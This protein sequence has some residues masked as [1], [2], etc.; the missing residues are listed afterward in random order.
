MKGVN[1]SPFAP[2]MNAFVERVNG[3]IRREA[4]EHYLLFSENQVRKIVK[5][6]VEYYN[7]HR[8]HQGV[9]RTPA[10]DQVPGFGGIKKEPI[11]GGLH[12]SYYRSRA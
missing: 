11:L 9:G 6:Y 8:P 10:G 5:S 2:N 4:L 1:I 7:H 3:S 12:H